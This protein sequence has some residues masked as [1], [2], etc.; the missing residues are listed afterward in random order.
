MMRISRTL[1][2]A[3]LGTG[4]LAGAGG[5]VAGH[6]TA[7]PATVQACPAPPG[8]H[9]YMTAGSHVTAGG[10]VFTCDA[11]GNSYEN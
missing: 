6:V 3:A 5:Y 10:H 1:V 4:L 9:G 11:S 2:M 7:P 8:Y